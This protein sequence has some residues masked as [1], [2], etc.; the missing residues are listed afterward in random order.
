MHISN[1]GLIFYILESFL[2]AVRIS[3]KTKPTKSLNAP[4]TKADSM[5]KRHLAENRGS[6]LGSENCIKR[7]QRASVSVLSNMYSLC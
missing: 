7:A 5:E 1:K 6:P 3:K 4:I 2:Q